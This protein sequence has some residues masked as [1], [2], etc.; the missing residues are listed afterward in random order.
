MFYFNIVFIMKKILFFS[1]LICFIYNF[2]IKLNKYNKQFNN[3][4]S[5]LVYNNQTVLNPYFDTNLI[6][7]DTC[8]C[9]YKE[10]Y[11]LNTKENVA[12]FTISYNENNDTI[13][14]PNKLLLNK[15]DIEAFYTLNKIENENNNNKYN[16]LIYSYCIF[17]NIP[18]N[19]NNKNYKNY[20]DF[21]SYNN[22]YNNNSYFGILNMSFF[23]NDK[24][25]SFSYL[26]FC[27]K[28][29]KFLNIL[30][31]IILFIIAMFYVF[32]STFIQMDFKIVKEFNDQI[33][34]PWYYGIIY[35]FIAS[36]V[37]LFLFYFINS[38]ITIFNILV[39]FQ[40]FICL[41]YT[42]KY[43]SKKFCKY[44]NPKNIKKIIYNLKIYHII[45]FLFSAI[46]VSLYFYIKNWQLNNIMAFGLVFYILSFL[47][48]K[49]FLVCFTFLIGIFLYDTFWV[50]YSHK[51]FT[52]NV[53]L[54]VATKIDLPIKLE[55]PIL[56]SSNP[57]KN[58]MLLGLG[59]LAL[60]GMVIKY[61]KRYDDL[62]KKLK[63]KKGGYYK[64]CFI[65]YICS[66]FSAM[67][68][69]YVF[70]SGQPVLFYISPAFIVGLLFRAFKKGELK[71][72]W[73]GLNDETKDKKKKD[74][75]KKNNNN[76]HNDLKDDSEKIIDN[77][78][79]ENDSDIKKIMNDKIKDSDENDNSKISELNFMNENE[80]LK[81]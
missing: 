36:A 26:K 3:Y 24:E 37:L 62:S 6:L 69:V 42:L 78:E 31:S 19:I 51:I 27:K 12:N 70:D 29:K 9:S 16:L 68:A 18:K 64:L 22:K 34:I 35:V 61:C 45:S 20:I 50:F 21:K 65:L 72:F 53:M 47:L 73:N 1:I 59:D 80:K 48:I 44:F 8:S 23:Y 75:D 67:V 63:R 13:F 4:S 32:L 7:N 33:D 52:D 76:N 14:N 43:F 28:E 25:Y 38:I 71:D 81:K 10:I 66:V 2:E 55:M 60:P 41:Y 30:S 17:D 54:T 58:C 79:K 15:R 49:N 57:L 74:E 39:A 77:N 5:Y 46:L 11:Y 40:C 56:F